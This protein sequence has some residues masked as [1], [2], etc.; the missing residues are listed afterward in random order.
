MMILSV[1]TKN[2][3]QGLRMEND[4]YNRGGYIAFLFSMAFS[5]AFFV[6]I[7]AVHPGVNLKEVKPPEAAAEQTLAG[8]PAAATIDISKVEK[9]WAENADVAAYGQK[10]F[11]NNCAVCHGPKG[12]GDGPAG[13]GLNPPPRNL[14]EG[15]WKVGGDS[16]ALFKTLQNGIPGGSMASFAHLPAADRWAMVQ[17]MRSITKNLVKDDPAKLE[18]FAKTAK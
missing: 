3:G 9:P 8:Q 18:A 17:Y 14:V 4:N 7:V 5:L 2:S 13:K 6:Y 11:S 16:I 1:E 15:K 12:E 10:I